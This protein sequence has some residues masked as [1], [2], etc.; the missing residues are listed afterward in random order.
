M[1]ET[2]HMQVFIRV[3]HYLRDILILEANKREEK[4]F[5]SK[6]LNIR[7]TYLRIWNQ[8]EIPGRIIGSIFADLH[9]IIY[10]V[11][12]KCSREVLQIQKVVIHNIV[13]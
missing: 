4:V 3:E 13:I 8:Y 7:S 9:H 10:P 12:S 2:Q 11:A 5:T 6:S 1:Q